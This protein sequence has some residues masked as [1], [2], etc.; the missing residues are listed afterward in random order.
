M[1]RIR[2]ISTK[3]TRE[4]KGMQMLKVNGITKL[5]N[6]TCQASR[7]SRY[8]W[9]SDFKTMV[10]NSVAI[11]LWLHENLNPSIE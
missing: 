6:R 2:A 11:V 7:G 10:R 4:A 8:L 5:V 9:Q 1:D 3:D